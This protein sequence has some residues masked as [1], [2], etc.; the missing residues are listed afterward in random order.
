MARRG[1]AAG[2]L[3]AAAAL[4]LA[5]CASAPPPDA[6]ITGTAI[7]RERL[8]MPP[9]AAFE[10]ALVD[11]TRAGEPPLVLARQRIGDAGGPPYALRLPYHQADIRPGGRYE[12]RAAT[13]WQ[14]RLWLDTPGVHPVLLSPQ[15]RHVDVILARVPQ[16]QATLD[17]AV[18]LRQTWWRLVELVDGPPVG[19]PAQG[20]APAHLVLEREE[21]RVAGSGGCNRFAGRFALEGGRLRFFG[22]GSSL[23]LCLD[24]G[25]S[26]LAYLQ[27]LAV[28]TSYLQEGRTLELRGDKGQPLLR[29]VAAERGEPRLEDEEPEMLPQ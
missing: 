22:L 27:Q 13:T 12:V 21:A 8:Y 17:A 19:E 18:P 23:R 28:V 29:F 25:A 20:A 15:F 4:L 3:A 2:A 7:S 24:G 1:A 26:E 10:A 11:V 6:L 5:G 14:G 16:L 9:E